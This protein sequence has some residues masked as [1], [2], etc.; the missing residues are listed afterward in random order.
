MLVMISP[1][2]FDPVLVW[3]YQRLLKTVMYFEISKGCC[4]REPPKRKSGLEMKQGVR[5]L[6]LIEK[7]K[8]A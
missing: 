2:L 3:S 5:S 4:L 7:L 6:K 8:N 1:T